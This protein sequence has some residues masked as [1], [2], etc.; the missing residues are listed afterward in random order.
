MDMWLVWPKGRQANKK[1]HVWPNFTFQ[2]N[3][4]KEKPQKSMPK[5]TICV[6]GVAFD[7]RCFNNKSNI[8]SQEH[9]KWKCFD[10]QIYSQ[11]QHL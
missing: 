8:K 6:L 9:P 5:W 1:I 3:I 2:L 10:I 4:T 11:L 7:V